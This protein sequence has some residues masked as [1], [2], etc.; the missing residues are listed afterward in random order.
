MSERQRE[1]TILFYTCPAHALAHIYTLIHPSVL[2]AMSQSFGL[3]PGQFLRYATIGSV[4]FGVGALPAGWLS[5]RVGE[6]SLLVAFF[7]LTAAGG[8]VLGLAG[9]VVGLATG[10]A[11][12]GA[13]ASIF[14]PVGNALISKGIRVPGRAMGINGLWGSLGTALAPIL[15]Y[16]IAAWSDWRWVYLLLAVPTT[17][18]GVALL[19]T[20]MPLAARSRPESAD[21]NE[22]D[23]PRR[24][25]AAQEAA[26][27][28][29]VSP[30]N[31]WFWVVITLLGATSLGGLYFFLITTMLPSHFEGHIQFSSQTQSWAASYGVGVCYALGGVG[32]VVAGNLMQRVDGRG[33]YLFIVAGAAPLIFWVSQS[34]DVPLVVGTAIMATFLFAAQPVENVLLARYS[35]A[36]YRGLIFGS[37]FILAFGM[38]GGLGTWLSGFI[39]DTHGTAAV[40]VVAS[41]CTA[42]AALILIG[43]LVPR[44][45]ASLSG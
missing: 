36:R 17:I 13:G 18:L 31:G 3:T 6:K 26:S 35:P 20:P 4:L 39:T 42:A 38:G 29:G 5:D 24:S 22:Q 8:V 23:T 43:L 28:V 25:T 7:F 9:G 30:P 10:F 19:R 2:F 45:R 41:G 33:L 21:D 32:Q 44:R 40:F 12:V 27:Q 37:K 1:R 16:Q 14:H 11:L 15:A 34:E